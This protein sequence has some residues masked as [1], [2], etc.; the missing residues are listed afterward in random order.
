MWIVLTRSKAPFQEMADGDR[1]DPA[2]A[3]VARGPGPPQRPPAV[4][5]RGPGPPRVPRT[6]PSLSLPRRSSREPRGGPETPT[7]KLPNFHRFLGLSRKV[8]GNYYWSARVH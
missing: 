2:S 8:P 6:L 4:V 7:D 5:A 3:V 1:P